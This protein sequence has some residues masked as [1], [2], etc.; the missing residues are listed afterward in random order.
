MRDAPVVHEE[1]SYI[2][3]VEDIPINSL[4]V[5]K[6]VPSINL[7]DI[8]GMTDEAD[9]DMLDITDDISTYINQCAHTG[10]RE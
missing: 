7:G 2:P 6:P 4:P 9:Q 8:S 5:N 10:D 1:R 3:Q